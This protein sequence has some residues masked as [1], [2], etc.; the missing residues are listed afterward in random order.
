MLVDD[1]N[2]LKGKMLRIL[3]EKG[4][5]DP[6]LDPGLDEKTLVKAYKTMILA[7]V[8]DDKAVKLQRQGR[9]GAYPPTLGQEASQ[10]GP[11]MALSERDW[12]VP[13]FRELGGMLWKGV[14]LE[15]LYLYWMGNEE[16]S[17]FPE[18]VRVT[19]VAIPVASQVPH[20]V[21]ISYAMRLRGEKGVTMTFFGDGGTSEGDFHEGLNLAGALRTPTVFIC[22]NNQYAISLRR[23]FQTASSSIAIKSIAYGF[24]GIQVDGN[25]LLALY[26]ASREA[27]ERARK[28]D[29]PTLIESFTYRMGD[30]TTSD[31]ASKYRSEREVEEWRKRDPLDRVRRYL[32]SQKM[33]D[34]EKERSAWE[35]AEGMVGDAVKAAESAPPPTLKDIFVHTYSSMPPRLERQMRQLEG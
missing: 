11:A 13:A 23:E 34:E 27:V 20:A 5:A 17:R 31:D 29:G 7:R 35:E 30:H 2:P 28:G 12:L 33:W 25:D 26:A 6:D 10:I 16:G 24:P 21:G 14:P 15:R 4:E 22:Q 9:L 18:G 8:A 1:Y 3:N 19:P 32:V